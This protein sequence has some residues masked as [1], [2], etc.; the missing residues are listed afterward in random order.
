[1]R[2]FGPGAERLEQQF[3]EIE[4]QRGYDA[5]VKWWYKAWERYYERCVLD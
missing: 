5:A 1:M 4:A 3:R 2:N